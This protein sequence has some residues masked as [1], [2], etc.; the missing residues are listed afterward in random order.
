MGRCGFLWVVD[1]PSSTSFAKKRYGG[2]EST[3][4]GGDR[5]VPGN[6]FGYQGLPGVTRTYQGPT[7]R[8]PATGH[9]RRKIKVLLLDTIG[10]YLILAD[11]GCWQ[12]P[13]G[14]GQTPEG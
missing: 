11:T 12:K 7:E 14:R 6:V 3:A 8:L 1:P 2:R 13:E 9:G 4:E 10:Y 5:A